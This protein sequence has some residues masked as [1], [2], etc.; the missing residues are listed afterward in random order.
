MAVT[1]QSFR[2]AWRASIKLMGGTEEDMR[3]AE[4]L[5]P[6]AKNE[7]SKPARRLRFAPRS[8]QHLGRCSFSARKYGDDFRHSQKIQVLQAALVECVRSN[9]QIERYW[10]TFVEQNAYSFQ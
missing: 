7:R 10:Q 8:C 2:D 3:R 1:D 5:F 9:F 6:K 4:E